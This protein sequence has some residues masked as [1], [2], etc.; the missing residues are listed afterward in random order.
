MDVVSIDIVN[1]LL[2]TGKTYSEISTELQQMYPHIIRGLP[3][4][5]VRRYVKEK[6]LKEICDRDRKH[7][8][9]DRITEVS[10]FSKHSISSALIVFLVACF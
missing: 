7:T 9:E 8:I 1:S 6:G 2:L 5:S 10:N 4:C 3:T